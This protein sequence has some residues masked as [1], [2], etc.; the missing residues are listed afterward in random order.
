MFR[1]HQI[2]QRSGFTNARSAFTLIELLVVIAIIAILAAILFPVFAQ[3]REKARQTSC[4]SNCKQIG[5]AFQMYSQDYDDGLPAW[6]EYLG[7]G[8]GYPEAGKPGVSTGYTGASSVL[9][10]N[11][12]GT[13]Q[14]KLTPYV[15]SGAPE[16][17]DNSG[18]WKCPSMGAKGE[19][20]TRTLTDGTTGTNYSYGYNQ[21]VARH[22]DAGFSS[23]GLPGYYRYPFLTD[24]GAPASTVMVG[25]ATTP[26][27]LAPN[28]WFQTWT[29][30]NS[31][32]SW[33]ESPTR[34]S[35]GSNYVYADGHAKWM[36]Q[37]YIFP[38]G[39][40]GGANSQK[41]YRSAIDHLLYSDRE[42]AAFR[43]LLR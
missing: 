31:P 10:N 18:V 32:T 40:R 33:W 13:W 29:Y 42:R 15:K 7:Q 6:D 14:A 19:R 37:Q 30:R 24:M 17:F 26:G 27:R 35:G 9:S 43:T 5:I 41:A 25:E 34:H 21:V 11:A 1:K 23:L 36:N 8:D 12:L 3:A 22:N 39:P 16:K 2:R 38:D 28:W 20:T 4:L